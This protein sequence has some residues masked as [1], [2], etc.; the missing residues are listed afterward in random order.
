MVITDK[1]NPIKAI[2]CVL[3]DKGLDVSLPSM[4]GMVKMNPPN[5]NPNDNNTHCFRFIAKYF[6]PNNINASGNNPNKLN[7][8]S[9]VGSA[10]FEK[11]SFKNVPV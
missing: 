4:K 8:I 6:S 1:I 10:L 11:T 7:T 3:L 9:K 2:T 5:I